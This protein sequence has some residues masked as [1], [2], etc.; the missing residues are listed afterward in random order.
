MFTVHRPN[1]AAAQAPAKTKPRRAVHRRRCET[2]DQSGLPHE[3]QN[4]P[5]TSPKARRKPVA[6]HVTVA[7]TR[8]LTAFRPLRS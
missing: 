8:A 2:R 3:R 6:N 7:D 4:T 5:L 1:Q